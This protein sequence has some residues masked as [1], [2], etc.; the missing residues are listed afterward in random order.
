MA[1]ENKDRTFAGI[2][3]RSIMHEPIHIGKTKRSE[4]VKSGRGA[5]AN[6]AGRFETLALAADPD[7]EPELDENGAIVQ[8]NPLKTQIFHDHS[9]TIL[10]TNDSPDIGMDYTLNPYR[11]CE[12]GCIYCFAR[13]THE[14]LGLSAGLDFE[15]K[16]FAKPDAPRLLADKLSSPKWEPKIIFMSGV[17]DP[18]QP[19]EKKLRIT[20]Q[21]LEVLVDFRNPVS[22]ITKNNL[23]I[24]DLDLLSELARH[25][26]VSVNMSVTTLDRH[27]ARVMEPRASTP[28][29]RLKAIEALSKAGVPVNVLMGPV[30]PGLTEHEIPALLKAAADAGA[31]AA[32]YTML[33]L[34]YGVK[35]L[36]E[37]WVKEHFPDRADKVLNRIKDIRDGK[38]NNSDFGSRMVGE[39]FYADQ[40]AQMFK[41]A[42]QK[43]GLTKRVVLSTGAFRRDA[44]N[45]QLSL[46]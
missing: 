21:C 39:G 4:Q 44:R 2:M 15:T 24:R 34:P 10:S 41:L 14:Y 8:P 25:N 5:L 38:L 37:D 16:I 19:I 36:F 20:R 33:R 1:D 9:K 31:V 26:C 7:L 11:G 12:H 18:Y 43:N 17:T 40:I 30:V 6:P 32:G 46:F 3:L 42:K 22:F 29:L 23:I 28:G 45:P 27:V 13:P 35:H